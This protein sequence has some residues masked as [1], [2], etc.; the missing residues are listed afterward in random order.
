MRHNLMDPQQHGAHETQASAGVH[1][2]RASAQ[3]PEAAPTPP[4]REG[5]TSFS[6]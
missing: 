2:S 6:V 4:R 3:D 5:E 1:D